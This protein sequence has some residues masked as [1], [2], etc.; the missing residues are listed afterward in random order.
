MVLAL[1]TNTYAVETKNF[2]QTKTKKTQILVGGSL[3]KDSNRIV[4]LKTKDFGQSKRW[5]TYTISRDGKIYQHFDPQFYSDYMGVKEIDKKA[6][7]VELENMGWVYFNNNRECF[8]NWIEEECD[9]T[10]SGEQ[11]W[12]NYRYWEKYTNEQHASLAQL[13]LYLMK[14][15]DIKKDAVGHNSL[16]T[17]IDLSTFE[18]IVCKSNYDTDYT[19]LNP[20]FD[21]NKFLKMMN[22]SFE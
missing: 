2:Y 10:L 3:R 20:F 14:E 12:K 6:I 1:D 8:V 22:I 13:C 7:S 4:H 5:P 17:E 15:F 9:G 11:C 16:E 18:G 19:D 21:F